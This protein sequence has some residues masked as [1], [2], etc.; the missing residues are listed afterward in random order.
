MKNRGFTMLEILVATALTALV[1]MGLNTLVFSMAELWGNGSPTRNFDLH[2]R[3]FTT[4]LEQEFRT[5][6]LAVPVTA[7]TS[8]TTGTATGTAAGST[9]A[10]GQAGATGGFSWQ[11]PS[12]STPGSSTQP[13]L[14]FTLP[15][16]SRLLPWPARALPDV[17]CALEA[18]DDG[19]YLLWHSEY[20]TNFVTDPPR[21]TLLTPL[22]TALAYDYYDADA[23]Q[24]TTTTEPTTDGNNQTLL[25][26]RMRLTFQFET[27]KQETTVIIPAPNQGLPPF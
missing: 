23:K 14:T 27:L 3:A 6:A 9:A 16:G 2:A 18:R 26:G 1:L 7:T 4:F 13:L 20:E 22:V 12:G 10:G 5:A 25:P 19:L 17:V 24:W 8:G 11:A 21:E 15:A